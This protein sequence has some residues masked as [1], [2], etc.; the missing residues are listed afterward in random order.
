MKSAR[1]PNI[2]QSLISKFITDQGKTAKYF[3]GKETKIVKKLVSKYSQEFFEWLPLPFGYKVSSFVYFLTKDGEDYLRGKY[4]EFLKTKINLT[5][6][7][8]K[9]LDSTTVIGDNIEIVKK[10]KNI[11]EFLSL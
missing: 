5:P 11:E 6:E 3:W 7:Q 1:K 9:H 4:F 2:Y 8:P 10:P